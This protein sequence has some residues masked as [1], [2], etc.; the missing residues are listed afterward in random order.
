M[1]PE[2]LMKKDEQ[3]GTNEQEALIPIP[4]PVHVLV[5]EDQP[6]T[7][8]P[9]ATEVD[10]ADAA[11]RRAQEIV[12]AHDDKQA[13]DVGST[14]TEPSPL[15]DNHE[16]P[17]SPNPPPPDW[18]LTWPEK[19]SQ[20]G[21]QMRESV[22][23]SNEGYDEA[24]APSTCHDSSTV[25]DESAIALYEG[26]SIEPRLDLADHGEELLQSLPSHENPSTS[27][28]QENMTDI[29]TPMTSPFGGHSHTSAQATTAPRPLQPTR[30][31]YGPD[32]REPWSR[33]TP[34]PF[35]AGTRRQEVMEHVDTP[36]SRRAGLGNWRGSRQIPDL[37]ESWRDRGSD[38]VRGRGWTR[39]PDRGR[40][41]GANRGRGGGGGRDWCERGRGFRGRRRG[42]RSG[43]DAGDNGD[44]R[45]DAASEV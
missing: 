44:S 27:G 7:E 34:T 26:M 8:L 2:E 6:T 39:G 22:L 28:Y 37:S 30:G 14:L 19:A 36:T 33:I 35:E 45:G 25:D 40:G 29:P 18:L 31:P 43:R 11:E 23:E 9:A 20:E 15:A 38:S 4:V 12:M 16:R 13:H 10:N 32:T 42:R 21:L 24:N 17:P 5:G 41:R 1:S 3:D